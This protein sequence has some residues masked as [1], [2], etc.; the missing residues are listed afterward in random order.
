MTNLV[1][2][3]LLALLTTI[4]FGIRV[5]PT[6]LK[7]IAI[8]RQFAPIANGVFIVIAFAMSFCVIRYSLYLNDKVQTQLR[9]DH[10][11]QM[12]NQVKADQNI[13]QQKQRDLE[14]KEADLKRAEQ[15]LRNNQLLQKQLFQQPSNEPP[16]P[17][18]VT[19]AELRCG[20]Y[21]LS[22]EQLT[23]HFGDHTWEGTTG[24]LKWQ[25]YYAQPQQRP[26]RESP[27]TFYA[28][29]SRNQQQLPSWQGRWYLEGNSY[30]TCTGTCEEYKCRVVK[31]EGNCA[32]K[33]WWTFEGSRKHSRITAMYPGDTRNR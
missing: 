32:A 13:A 15:E 2:S 16:A 1:L 12:E 21:F 25:E 7:S 22:A 20:T 11:N 24:N 27:G 31:Q 33:V 10:L 14:K 6:I 3:I 29:G 18:Q 26:S 19:P 5:V 4:F 30:C 8:P 23:A 9:L 17:S 28:S